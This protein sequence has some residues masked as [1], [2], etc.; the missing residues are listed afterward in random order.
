VYRIGDLHFVRDSHHRVSIAMATGQQSIE[1]Y[2]T[3]VITSIPADGIRRRDDQL[4][5][6]CERI[7]QARVPLPPASQAKTAFT[8]PWCLPSWARASKRGETGA[9]MRSG[10][11]WTAGDR[12]VLVRRGVD[13]GRPDARRHDLIGRRTDAEAYLRIAR[14]RYRLMRTHDWSDEIIERLRGEIG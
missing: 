6:G 3:E 13:S 7:F 8:N 5:K 11:S 12:Q 14:E 9:F 10:G 1:G 4:M 2:V